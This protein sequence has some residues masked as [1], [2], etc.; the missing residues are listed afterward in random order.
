MQW[1]QVIGAGYQYSS[2]VT[3]DKRFFMENAGH[4]LIHEGK[5]NPDFIWREVL[6]ILRRMEMGQW[7]RKL[8][9][10]TY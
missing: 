5:Y 1:Y 8:W 2:L 7:K 6:N 4:D 9:T 10:V 3:E